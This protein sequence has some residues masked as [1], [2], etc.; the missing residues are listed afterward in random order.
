[1]KVDQIGSKI[2]I[3]CSDGKVYNFSELGQAIQFLKSVK[4]PVDALSMPK[5]FREALANYSDN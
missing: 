4:G 3:K 5:S 1:M 2:R